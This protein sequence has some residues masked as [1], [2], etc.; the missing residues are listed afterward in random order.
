[1]NKPNKLTPDLVGNSIKVDPPSSTSKDL[2][3]RHTLGT[4]MAMVVPVSEV[5]FFDRNP[6][7]IHDPEEFGRLKESIR[8]IGVQ[9]PVHIT[10]RPGSSRYMLARGGNSRL[11]CL[12]ELIAETGDE[13]FAKIPAVYIEYTSELDI[14]RDHLIENEQRSDMFFW[15][16]A[17]AYAEMRDMLQESEGKNLGVRPLSDKFSEIGLTVYF[18]KLSVYLFAADN[19]SALG[20]LCSSL[21]IQ[22]ATDLRKLHN[23]LEALY[24]NTEQSDK[25][26]FSE[27]WDSSLENWANADEDELDVQALQSS[28]QQSFT[29]T[30]NIAP[31][32]ND[33]TK[34][35]SENVPNSESV[36]PKNDVE[37]STSTSETAPKS[38]ISNTNPTLEENSIGSTQSDSV[39]RR[40]VDP[41]DGANN[42][43][44]SAQTDVFIQNNV[45]RTRDH[46]VSDILASVKKL[47]ACVNIESLL[48]P[49]DKMP[50]GWM[51]D[52]PDFSK[53]GWD[54]SDDQVAMINVRHDLAATIFIYLWTVS[55]Q[56]TLWEN[57]Q[58]LKAY[59]PFTN[60]PNATIQNI[61]PDEN[62][63]EDAENFAIAQPIYGNNVTEMIFEFILGNDEARKAYFNVI[64]Y[65]AELEK[66]SGDNWEMFQE[67]NNMKR[68]GTS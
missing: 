22:K 27:F 10:T 60:K 2:G 46:V 28:L 16:K 55:G 53:P 15:D 56:K 17:C 36:P 32:N 23:E 19:L 6:R 43:I 67:M 54:G 18:T 51:L 14:L 40:P 42:A 61:Y 41:D 31:K 30:F 9:H 64:E 49:D 38:P 58:L 37:I 45:K 59:N 24:K 11:L 7:H 44:E 63:R 20:N 57:P 21:S 52:F 13:R 12:K 26:A 8:E 68:E 5:D 35:R 65:T 4:G 34:K 39:T 29:D 33:G 62:L 48:I 25:E 1:M 66:M 50:Y 3:R 47:M